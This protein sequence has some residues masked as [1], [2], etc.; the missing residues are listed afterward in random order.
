MAAGWRAAL[1]VLVALVAGAVG[2]TGAYAFHWHVIQPSDAEI[3]ATAPELTPPGFVVDWG[4]DVSGKWAPSLDRGYVRM[5]VSS[6]DQVTIETIAADLLERGWA[7]DRLDPGEHLDFL[8]ATKDDLWLHV[9]RTTGQGGVGGQVAKRENGTSAEF[10]LQ[11]GTQSPSLTTT[12]RLG[13]LLAA[14]AGSVI[15]VWLTRRR[16]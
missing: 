10:T 11:R 1:V 15:T 16:T 14:G 3:L 8:D 12:V 2:A 13:A 9:T 5:G 6:D 4:P 7:T